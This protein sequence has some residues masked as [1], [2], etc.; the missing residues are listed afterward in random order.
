AALRRAVSLSS[1][2]VTAMATLI[3]ALTLLVQRSAVAGATSALGAA[4]LAASAAIAVWAARRAFRRDSGSPARWLLELSAAYSI[5]MSLGILA[6]V[7]SFN[8]WQ[9]LE[10]L[11]NQL[12]PDLAGRPVVLWHPDETTEAW[13]EMYL[14][15]APALSIL[16]TEANGPDTLRGFL[17]Q[18]PDARILAL[19]HGPAWGWRTW[20]RYLSGAGMLPAESDP[21]LPLSD[22]GLKQWTRV[23]RPGGRAYRVLGRAPA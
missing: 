2:L 5:L 15:G 13:V 8:R 14:P 20:Q 6:L 16:G 4:S 21:K 10:T 12:K 17:D 9:D 3:F 19:E 7:M 11:S 18:H 22:L 23:E 1:L